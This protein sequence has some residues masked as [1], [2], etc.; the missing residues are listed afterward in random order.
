MAGLNHALLRVRGAVSGQ[1][2]E[3]AQLTFE[4]KR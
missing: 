2:K 1:D 4:E 3:S